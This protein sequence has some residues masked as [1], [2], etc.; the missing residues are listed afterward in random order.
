MVAHVIGRKLNVT[1]LLL[2]LRRRLD[3]INSFNPSIAHQNVGV[4]THTQLSS[5]QTIFRLAFQV[6]SL[7]HAD[8]ALYEHY[9]YSDQNRGTL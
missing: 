6:H 2:F 9:N 8:A 5:V 1:D 3:V 7:V 4:F